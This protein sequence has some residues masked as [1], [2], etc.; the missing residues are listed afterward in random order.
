MMI[1]RPLLGVLLF[2]ATLLAGLASPLPASPLHASPVGADVDVRWKDEI[3]PI[4]A[5]PLEVSP[6]A[7]SAIQTWAAWVEANRYMM[8]LSDD[9]RVLVISASGPS[10]RRQQRVLVEK[11]IRL[12]DKKLP[13]PAVRLAMAAPLAKADPEGG[14]AGAPGKEGGDPLPDDPEGGTHP[15]ESLGDVGGEGLDDPEDVTWAWGAGTVAPDTETI[16]FFVLRHPAEYEAI[17]D[18]LA[19]ISPYLVPWIAKAKLYTGFA[20]QQPLAGCYI[21]TGEG[22]EEWSPDAE[23][24]NRLASLLMLRRFGRQP[25]W[26][27]QGWAWQAELDIRGGIYCFPYRDEFV[28][29]T[30]H[31]GWGAALRSRF[32]RRADKPVRLEEF[33]TWGR[34]AYK[35]DCAKL[36]WGMVGFLV[37][38]EKRRLPDL[39]ETLR[40]YRDVHDRIID[41][42]TEWHRDPDYT[43]PLDEL[44]RLFR[45]HLGD[46][47][48]TKAT[49]Y[50]RGE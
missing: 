43:I 39:L 48:L 49:A 14:G 12:F 18:V 50:F 29:A 2:V 47:Y 4:T 44:D 24:V 17:L 33:A 42:A 20:I 23:L 37:D 38:K 6:A 7:L 35:D 19:K 3:Y 28:A 15:W 5:L 31:E 25:Y 36:S 22:R 45:E 13:A 34:G 41:S 26:M 11:T 40:A 32:A 10:R 16:V 46:D 27:T 21:E 9:G 1:H 30:E 8:D